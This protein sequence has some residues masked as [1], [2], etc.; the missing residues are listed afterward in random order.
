MKR[1][2]SFGK[3]IR[4]IFR[5][6]DAFVFSGLLTLTVLLAF[7]IGIRPVPVIL[8]SAALSVGILLLRSHSESYK[9][10]RIIAEE[11]RRRKTEQLLLMSDR[12]IGYF[13]GSD[14][15]YLIRTQRPDLCSA[16]EAIRHRPEEI[17]LLASSEEVKDVLNRY[18]PSAR[19]LT[20]DELLKTVFDFEIEQ[21]GMRYDLMNA[22]VN[23]KINKYFLIGVMIFF[24]SFVV[25]Y[26]IYYRF[27]SGICL[28]IATITGFFRPAAE[29]KNLRIFLDKRGDR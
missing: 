22:I 15:F 7:R 20:I 18:V 10:K 14:R 21:V 5:I 28:I 17:G 19:I 11:E 3:L 6:L 9:R 27:I 4:W 16:M 24:A 8:C 26:K 1:R 2:N 12:E 13:V 23:G 29:K 25:R